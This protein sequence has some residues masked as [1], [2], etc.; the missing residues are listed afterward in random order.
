M[1]KPKVSPTNFKLGG[2]RSMCYQLPWPP[3][4]ACEVVLLQPGGDM[5]CQKHTEM[6]VLK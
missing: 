3:I 5:L 2:G 1:L 6:L 4:K